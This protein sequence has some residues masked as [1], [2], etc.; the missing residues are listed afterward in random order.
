MSNDNSTEMG[1]RGSNIV[2]RNN[3]ISPH[4]WFDLYYWIS[5]CKAW[6]SEPHY[7]AGFLLQNILS[8][9]YSKL[10]I[11]QRRHFGTVNTMAPGV[12][13][14][15]RTILQPSSANITCWRR[16]TYNDLLVPLCALTATYRLLEQLQCWLCWCECGGRFAAWTKSI[17]GYIFYFVHG[18]VLGRSWARKWKRAWQQELLIVKEDVDNRHQCW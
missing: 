14:Q 12:N 10:W 2:L 6:M 5:E 15:D 13:P 9:P 7:F 8:I 11:S 18:N 1:W 3:A 17:S 16:R 4:Q